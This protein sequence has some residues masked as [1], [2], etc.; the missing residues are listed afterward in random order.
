ML[1][2]IFFSFLLHRAPNSAKGRSKMTTTNAKIPLKREL[3]HLKGEIMV[4]NLE[5]VQEEKLLKRL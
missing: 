4:N 1:T 3:L 2:L 5:E